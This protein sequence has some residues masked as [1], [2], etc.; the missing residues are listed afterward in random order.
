[1]QNN[2]KQRQRKKLTQQRNGGVSSCIASV[3]CVDRYETVQ[4]S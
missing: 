2:V 3:A 4:I 1:M